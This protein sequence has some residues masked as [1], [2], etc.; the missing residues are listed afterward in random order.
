MTSLSHV[1]LLLLE[2]NGP[3]C[4]TYFVSLP[5]TPPSPPSQIAVSEWDIIESTALSQHP[6]W[7]SSRWQLLH[8]HNLC[9]SSLFVAQ[10]Y[11]IAEEDHYRWVSSMFFLEHRPFGRQRVCQRINRCISRQAYNNMHTCIIKI[12]W[13]EAYTAKPLE[14]PC[15]WIDLPNLVQT[16]ESL[17]IVQKQL[18]THL[19]HAHLTAYCWLFYQIKS[20]QINSNNKIK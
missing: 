18:K 12:F 16:A 10:H 5:P 6:E 2:K 1:S 20:N 11:W 8:L 9:L 19:F 15:W 3:S 17:T 14:V 4:I 13:Y 7:Q